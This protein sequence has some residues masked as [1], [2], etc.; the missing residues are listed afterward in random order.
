MAR[1]W[2][3]NQRTVE[4]HLLG[5]GLSDVMSLPILLRVPFV[6]LETRHTT[7]NLGHRQQ[8]TIRIYTVQWDAALCARELASD[9]SVRAVPPQALV[10]LARSIGALEAGATRLLTLDRRD[11]ERLDLSG[12]ELIVPGGHG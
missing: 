4:K 12:I 3:D 10:A 8:Y 11:F 7:E 2:C 9:T 1:V 5:L 6:P